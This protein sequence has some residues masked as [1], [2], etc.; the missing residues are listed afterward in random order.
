MRWSLYGTFNVVSSKRPKISTTGKVTR[1]PIIGAWENV[2]ELQISGPKPHIRLV[3]TLCFRL[4]EE[5]L[6]SPN[7]GSSSCPYFYTLLLD[8]IG[9]VHVYDSIEFLF[10]LRELFPRHLMPRQLTKPTSATHLEAV[11][12]STPVCMFLCGLT[13]TL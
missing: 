6:W 11:Y 9:G 2:N 12:F 4:T 1:R 7:F 10:D 8:S 3:C 13:F 5:C